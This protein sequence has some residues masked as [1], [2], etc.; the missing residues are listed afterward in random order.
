MLSDPIKTAIAMKFQILSPPN[1]K[2]SL[3]CAD[4]NNKNPKW[5][6]VTALAGNINITLKNNITTAPTNAS[7]YTT[8]I[9]VKSVLRLQSAATN[10]LIKPKF[11]TL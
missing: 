8:Y 3:V 10:I 11:S 1:V 9:K 4:C 5:R 6:V 7:T 2:N